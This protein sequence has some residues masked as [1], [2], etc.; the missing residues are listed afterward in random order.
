MAEGGVTGK[1]FVKGDPRINRKG[2][3][4][5]FDA[6]RAMTQGIATEWAKNNDGSDLM[7]NGRRISVAEVI[8][9]RWAMSPDPKWQQAFL[10]YAFGK[11]PSTTELTGKDGGPLRVEDVTAPDLSKLSDAELETLEAML[12]KATPDD[13]QP[14][15]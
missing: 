5:S 11:V 1:G 3:P 15:E 7:Y 2:R 12:A 10:E 9:R 13:A 6:L 8:M 4:K 14:T